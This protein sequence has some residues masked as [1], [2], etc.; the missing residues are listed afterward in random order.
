MKINK[1]IQI[2]WRLLGLSFLLTITFSSL[3]V[4][5][6]AD[7]PSESGEWKYH[8][9]YPPDNVDYFGGVLQMYGDSTVNGVVYSRLMFESGDFEG[10][11]RSNGR[12]VYFM[13]QF[14]STEYL[15]YDFDLEVGD[16]FIVPEYMRDCASSDTLMV[17]YVYYVS[18]NDSIERKVLVLDG[19]E[20]Y[21]GLGSALGYLHCW[22]VIASSPQPYRYCAIVDGEI[23]FERIVDILGASYNC[24]GR[25]VSTDDQNTAD[26]SWRIFQDQND[27]T[28]E[29][30]SKVP[31]LVE[32]Y[33]LSG[34]KLTDSQS[35]SILLQDS[36]RG[37]WVVLRI[38]SFSDHY[39]T[40]VW[41]N[42]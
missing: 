3:L 13:P 39:V 25:I 21:E 37:S 19:I 32:L 7:F 35:S 22:E 42:Y 29:H 5:Q 6:S 15:I 8:I 41:V 33:S 27:L 14:D 12:Q 2:F 17:S 11:I 34:R 26:R 23:A 31:S 30:E 10:L 16:Q 20:W 38:V 9:Y 18:F 40:K 28:V 1:Q 24:N 36:W 4:A